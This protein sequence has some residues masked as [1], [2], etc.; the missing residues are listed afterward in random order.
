MFT[1]VRIF[2]HLDDYYLKNLPMMSLTERALE[3]YR[4]SVFD[5]YLAQ[6]RDSI[7]KEIGKD[8]EDEVVDVDEIKNSAIIMG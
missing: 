6:L 1:M 2:K 7:F 5:K 4:T 8:R 3:F